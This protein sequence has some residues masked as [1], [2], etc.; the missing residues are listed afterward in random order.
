[1]PKAVGWAERSESHLLA[2]V[3]RGAVTCG[4]WFDSLRLAH[5]GLRKTVVLRRKQAK[6]SVPD[7]FRSATIRACPGGALI[8]R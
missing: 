7:L 2:P 4:R 3:P 1:M 8:D 5:P 6:C